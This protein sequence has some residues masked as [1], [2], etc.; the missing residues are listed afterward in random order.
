MCRADVYELC[1]RRNPRNKLPSSRE[2]WVDLVCS[3]PEAILDFWNQTRLTDKNIY[4]ETRW[5]L[6]DI[7]RKTG[8]PSHE[9]YE[10]CGKY[11]Y[12]RM[13][14][15]GSNFIEAHQQISLFVTEYGWPL[16]RPCEGYS[17]LLDFYLQ[18]TKDHY[19]CMIL[20]RYLLNNVTSATLIQNS[21]IVMALL[22]ASDDYWPSTLPE[23]LLTLFNQ[24]SEEDKRV[25]A[26]KKH[27]PTNVNSFMVDF[28]FRSLRM[29]QF[30]KA[31]WP[32]TNITVQNMRF[33]IHSQNTPLLL[34]AWCGLHDVAAEMF[35]MR[36]DPAYIRTRNKFGL[37]LLYHL[38]FLF[39]HPETSRDLI[40]N[41]SFFKQT[42]F[43][44]IELYT[45]TE[46][47][48]RK[49]GTVKGSPFEY[50]VR[51]SHRISP[52]V[53]KSVTSNF[54]WLLIAL[55][56]HDMYHFNVLLKHP[57]F[58]LR[59]LNLLTWEPI[60][61]AQLSPEAIVCIMK[62]CQLLSRYAQAAQLLQ[63]ERPDDELTIRDV[64]MYIN[65]N[66]LIHT[67]VPAAVQEGMPVHQAAH[68]AAPVVHDVVHD[69]VTEAAHDVVHDVAPVVHDVVH[70]AAHDVVHDAAHDVV[71]DAAHDVVHDAAHDAA[72]DV[73][74]D[75][76]HDVAHDVAHD[77]AHDVVHD[78]AHDVAHDVAPVV[79]D[80]VHEAAHDVVHDAAHDVAHDVAPVVVHDAA[81]DV[82]HDAAHDVAPVVTDVVTEAA[83]DVAHDVVHDVVHDVAH[84]AA[85]DVAPV[86]HDAAH[87]VVHEAAHDV[88]PVLVHD[89]AHDLEN[90]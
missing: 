7:A 49:L 60:Q 11:I 69:V 90:V 31:L 86:V 12:N 34:A 30:S 73:V 78:A 58:K 61:I 20:T 1:L 13:V 80:V 84:E 43:D 66:D 15:V 19:A 56:K 79:H 47:Y 62:R 55:S 51:N 42:T 57:Q 37:N 81:H 77:A 18:N 40:K 70:E 68:D 28:T 6:N 16:D 41:S 85:H 35:F 82:V 4:I 64:R 25:F 2:E 71:H 29:I 36:N 24:L 48:S 59:E 5:L 27:D 14:G 74:H 17:S 33:H 72:H 88:A 45:D 54:R 39:I 21:H 9:M 65:A 52:N 3:N 76:A 23:I 8:K 67:A 53:L 83:H 46:P 22:K 63:I 38:V 89:A 10:F 50:I 75:A 44:V 26:N 87:D 32:Y